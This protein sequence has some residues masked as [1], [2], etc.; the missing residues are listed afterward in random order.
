MGDWNTPH[1]ASLRPMAVIYVVGPDDYKRVYH[2]PLEQIGTTGINVIRMSTLLELLNQP[3]NTRMSFAVV[4]E[5]SI[6][7]DGKFINYDKYLRLKQSPEYRYHHDPDPAYYQ[8]ADVFIRRR[9]ARDFLIPPAPLPLPP[10]AEPPFT[11]HVD[12]GFIGPPSTSRRQTEEAP[13]AP[14]FFTKAY[15]SLVRTPYR[16]LLRDPIEALVYGR[17]ERS[18]DEDE[19]AEA[20]EAERYAAY[21]AA[22]A[23]KAPESGGRRIRRDALGRFV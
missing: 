2:V 7:S 14:G 11:F 4:L 21:C 6:T 9:P 16:R 3:P 13:Q 10:I 1:R 8:N 20:A 15:R 19:K 17:A 5:E 18:F 23:A 22:K 12:S